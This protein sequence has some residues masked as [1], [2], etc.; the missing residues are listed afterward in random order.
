[1]ISWRSRPV[2]ALGQL[3]GGRIGQR[4]GAVGEHDVRPGGP[5]GEIGRDLDSVA[6]SRIAGEGEA[7]VSGDSEACS[8]SRYSGR[9]LC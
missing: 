9:K 1:M 8:G 2:E 4:R 6:L 3:G 5:E 7:F